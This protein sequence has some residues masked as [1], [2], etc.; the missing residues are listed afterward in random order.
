MNRK[1]KIDLKT[2]EKI[3]YIITPIDT[4]IIDNAF[5]TIYQTRKDG[6][7]AKSEFLMRNIKKI[8]IVEVKHL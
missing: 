4:C 7:I 3:I 1:V 8:K 6:R 2:G 5:I